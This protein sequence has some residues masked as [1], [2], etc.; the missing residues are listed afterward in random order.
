VLARI[1]KEQR[2]EL[3][4][5]QFSRFCLHPAPQVYMPAFLEAMKYTAATPEQVSASS[6]RPPPASAPPPPS[7]AT[8]TTRGWTPRRRAARPSRACPC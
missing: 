7:T 1:L 6:A 8:P 5:I 4:P 2:I 3:T